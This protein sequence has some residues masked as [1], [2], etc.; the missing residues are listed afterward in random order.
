MF[1]LQKAGG[2]STSKVSPKAAGKRKSAGGRGRQAKKTKKD[3]SEESEEEVDDEEEEEDDDID[4]SEEEEYSEEEK[5]KKGQKDSAPKRGRAS[6]NVGKNQPDK[7]GNME[8][9][10]SRNSFYKFWSSN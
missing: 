6:T 5:P 10:T 3:D 1:I 9:N 4:E 2:R 8:V 7:D